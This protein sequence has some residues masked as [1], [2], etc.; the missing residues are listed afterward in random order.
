MFFRKTE[1]KSSQK[2]FLTP[3]FCHCSEYSYS[4]LWCSS[5]WNSILNPSK[6]IWTFLVSKAQLVFILPLTCIVTF[7]R[8]LSWTPDKYVLLLTWHTHLE[9]SWPSQTQHD[10]HLESWFYPQTDFTCRFLCL[11]WCNSMLPVS[12]AKLLEVTLDFFFSHGKLFL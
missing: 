3:F 7:S 8:F 6:F 5:A 11:S 4:S 9:I 12:Q 10:Q 2:C 1:K